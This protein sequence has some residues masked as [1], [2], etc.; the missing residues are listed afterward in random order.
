MFDKTQEA[1]LAFLLLLRKEKMYTISKEFHWS[2]AHHLPHLPEGHKCRNHHGHNYLAELILSKESL[3]ERSFV[4]DYGELDIF[5]Q[6]INKHFDHQDLNEV[7]DI[8]TT[9]ENIARHLYAVAKAFWND[10]QIIVR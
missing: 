2:A 5:K 1:E 3:D 4:V 10:C 6:Y 7:L 9:A 8:P